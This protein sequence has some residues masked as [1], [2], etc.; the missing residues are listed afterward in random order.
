MQM[1]GYFYLIYRDKKFSNQF[2]I[3]INGSSLL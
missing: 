1:N 3:L 2:T